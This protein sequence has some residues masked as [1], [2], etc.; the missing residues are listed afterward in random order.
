MESSLAGELQEASRSLRTQEQEYFRK[1]KSYEG[2][3]I[4]S[5]IQLTV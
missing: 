4:N 1:I 5:A 3:T 2:S